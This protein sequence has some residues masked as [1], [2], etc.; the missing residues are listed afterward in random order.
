M[1]DVASLEHSATL[2]RAT[3]TGYIAAIIGLNGVH[4]H[5]VSS[6]WEKEGRPTVRALLLLLLVTTQPATMHQ[7]LRLHGYIV[8]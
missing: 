8:L 5:A 7:I 2:F 1:I 6:V 3:N 4:R